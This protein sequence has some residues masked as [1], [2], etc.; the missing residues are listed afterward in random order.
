MVLDQAR[1]DA[2]DFVGT[3]GRAHTAPANCHTAIHLA[4]SHGTAERNH[5]IGVII[6]RGQLVCAEIRDLVTGRAKLGRQ[7]FLQLETP[8]I[9]GDSNAHEFPFSQ[10]GS[11][12]SAAARSASTKATSWR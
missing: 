11:V 3:D 8:V 7:F 12:F 6:A 10:S 2:F 4:G 5:E 9:S 1:A